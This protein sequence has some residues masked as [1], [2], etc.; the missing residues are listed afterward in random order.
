MGTGLQVMTHISDRHDI[1][2][3]LL[4]VALNTITLTLQIMILYNNNKLLVPLNKQFVQ[5]SHNYVLSD[6]FVFLFQIPKKIVFK[7]LPPVKKMKRKIDQL[8]KTGYH[9][10]LDEAGKK[11]V[12][13]GTTK[14]VQDVRKELENFVDNS[15]N[16]NLSED[17]YVALIHL[18]KHEPWFTQVESYLYE[19]GTLVLTLK[20][21]LD[22]D[23]MLNNIKSKMQDIRKM[24]ETEIHL[25]KKMTIFLEEIEKEVDESLKGIFCY[26]SYNKKRIL[27]KAP[28]IK[29]AQEAKYLVQVNIGV[30]VP[31]KRK[32]KNVNKSKE[33]TETKE[34]ELKNGT[35]FTT[36]EGID[37]LVY[38]ADFQKLKVECLVSPANQNLHHLKGIALN[39]AQAG[40][41]QIEKE[42]EEYLVEK[43][44]L[45]LGTCCS[46]SAGNLPYH[47]I[48]H[49]VIST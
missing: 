20:K 11:A 38:R 48:I 25:Q 22:P 36:K 42:C 5:Y 17:D 40:G 37:I 21:G 2:E 46:T 12:L 34:L 39:V 1:T 49:T 24:S 14:E 45:I 35:Q 30:A 10:T 47:C 44:N 4:K 33:G 28:N 23:Q 6:A 19:K 18:G 29:K 32:K 15:L 13:E 31:V 26:L 43:G 3:I 9:I 7:I 16:I 8:Q 41:T 27:I